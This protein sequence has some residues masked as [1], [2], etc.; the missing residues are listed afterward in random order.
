[1]SKLNKELE[2]LKQNENTPIVTEYLRQVAILTEG[3]EFI[4]VMLVE[5]EDDDFRPY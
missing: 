4:P 5:D 1:M 3:A 2:L